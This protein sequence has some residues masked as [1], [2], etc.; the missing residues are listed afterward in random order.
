MATM[1][2][3]DFL[4][5]INKSNFA[6]NPLSGEQVEKIITGLAKLPPAQVAKL[7]D[8]LGV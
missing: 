6:I 3:A 5:E 1:K 7:K 8:A 4:S 2:D